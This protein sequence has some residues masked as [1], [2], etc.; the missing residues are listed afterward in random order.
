[1]FEYTI[2]FKLSSSHFNADA[3]SRIPIVVNQEDPPVPNETVFLLENIAE[4]AVSVKQIRTWTNRDPLLSRVLQFI[5]S[6][7]IGKFNWIPLRLN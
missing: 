7:C 6:G 5:L 4:S 3:L 1:M 2:S